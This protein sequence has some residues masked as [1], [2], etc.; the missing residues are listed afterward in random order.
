MIFFSILL[1]LD[2]MGAKFQNAIPPIQIAAKV[3]KLLNFFLNGP[4]KSLGIFEIWNFND[5]FFVFDNMGPYGSETVKILFL[6]QIAA[7]CF[8]ICPDIGSRWSSQNYGGIF[9]K[10]KFPILNN[11]WISNSPLYPTEG[12][13]TSIVWKKNDRREKRSEMWDSRA[14]IE[15]ISCTFGIAAF[16]FFFGDHSMH[17]AIFPKMPF[18]K[19]RFLYT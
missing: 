1:T 8:Q 3:F 4:H 18:S 10:V 16:K 19:W 17:F 2:P 9:F 15:H 12:T 11:I 6:L 13:N 7:I 14:V 5:F